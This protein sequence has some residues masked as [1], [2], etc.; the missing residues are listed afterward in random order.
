MKKVLLLYPRLDV[1][2]GGIKGQKVRVDKK[3]INDSNRILWKKFL[4]NLIEVYNKRSDVDLEVLEMPLFEFTPKL[5]ESKKP[6][7]VFVP[8]KESHQFKVR[9]IPTYYYMQTAMRWM[10]SID[11]KGWAGGASVYPFNSIFNDN[12]DSKAFEM[13]RERALTNESKIAQPSFRELNLPENFVLFACQ[14][15]TD[16]TI[17]FHSKVDVGKALMYTLQT[18]QRLNIPLVVKPHPSRQDTQVFLKNAVSNFKHAIWLPNASIHQLI[19]MSK[20]LVVVNSGTGMEALLHKKPVVTF[21]KAEYDCVANPATRDTLDHV[22]NNLT[23][24]QQNV[25]KFFDS[26]YNWCY[27][28]DNIETFNKLP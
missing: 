19:Q 15:P 12:I 11:S 16:Q 21:G 3:L 6:D 20:C 4:D 28:T 22:L 2:F 26:W 8:H 13:F 27:D 10:F 1:N 14:V 25:Y 7:I 23:Y 9:D 17:K 18:T 5:V 24:D